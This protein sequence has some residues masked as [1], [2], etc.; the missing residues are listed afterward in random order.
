MVLCETMFLVT[1]WKYGKIVSPGS[2]FNKTRAFIPPMKL[3]KSLDH[4]NFL[5]KK[6]VLPPLDGPS[7]AWCG[8]LFGPISRL[9]ASDVLT[10]FTSLTT[11]Q[12]LG[13]QKTFQWCIS[14]IEECWFNLNYISSTVF[15]FFIFKRFSTQGE[16]ASFFILESWNAKGF[17]RIKSE[18]IDL[19]QSCTLVKP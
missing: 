13:L 5:F 18:V 3:F 7:I 9:V 6:I 19:I 4:R 1:H 12:L 16:M 2:N 17:T 14:W 11:N 15:F 8:S 10:D